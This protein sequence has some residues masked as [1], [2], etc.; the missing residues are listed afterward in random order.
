MAI[1]AE[2]MHFEILCVSGE[3]PTG[4]SQAHAETFLNKQG[5]KLYSSTLN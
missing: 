4:T 5:K 2:K 1:S 3:A